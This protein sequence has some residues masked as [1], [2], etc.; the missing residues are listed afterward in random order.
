MVDG[1]I[2]NFQAFLSDM[3]RIVV[4]STTPYGYCLIVKQ[5]LTKVTCPAVSTDA[6]TKEGAYCGRSCV[7]ALAGLLVAHARNRHG[8][9][10]AM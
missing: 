4:E 7:A 5:P 6:N 10:H 3:P 9:H 2:Q 1:E 8:A